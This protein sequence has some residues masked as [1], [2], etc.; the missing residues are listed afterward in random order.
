MSEFAQYNPIVNSFWAETE[1]VT[2]LEAALL[3]LGFEPFD[4][5]GYAPEPGYPESTTADIAAYY[6]TILFLNDRDEPRR[7]QHLPDGLSTK[8]EALRSAIRTGKINL[9]GMMVEGN[10]GIDE[11]KTRITMIEFLAWCG[12]KGIAVSIPGRKR[13]APVSEFGEPG[14]VAVDAAQPSKD[15]PLST[16]ER[17]T[18]LKMI[19]GMAVDA[20]GYAPTDPK[21]PLTGAGETSLHA[22]LLLRGI[23]VHPDTIRNYLKEAKEFLP[24]QQQS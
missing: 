17:E 13:S 8:I 23:S 10:G 5:V 4:M 21:S 7:S 15:K 24:P 11:T 6:R 22:T 9:V 14:Q 20:Y 1:D 18:L 3:S 2:L 19:I 16:K 12:E